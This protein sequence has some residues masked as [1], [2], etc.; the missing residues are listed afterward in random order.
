M[1]FLSRIFKDER[2]LQDQ[3]FRKLIR[4]VRGILDEVRRDVIHDLV[5]ERAGKSDKVLMFA[6]ER[7]DARYTPP[8]VTARQGSSRPSQHH[9]PG[10]ATSGRP[11]R[12]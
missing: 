9:A 4:G 2:T 5:H 1:N 10:R 12:G 3:R 7:L 6:A 11:R 8:N